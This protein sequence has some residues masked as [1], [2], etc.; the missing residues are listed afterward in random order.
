ML[1]ATTDGGTSWQPLPFTTAEHGEEPQKHPSGSVT[2]WSGRVWHR[3]TAA[4]PA[5]ARLALRW[6][7]TTDKLYVGRG[8]YVDGLRVEAAHGVL[9]DE[10]RTADAARLVATG[11]AESAD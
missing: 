4:L 1:E 3:V 8:A 2:G 9:F 10:S 7:Y 11:W 6:R 5:H